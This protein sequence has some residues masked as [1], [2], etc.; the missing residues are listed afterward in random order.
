MSPEAAEVCAATRT[1]ADLPAL[2]ALVGRFVQRYFPGYGL[3]TGKLNAVEA[4]RFVLSVV[5]EDG[6]EEELFLDQAQAAIKP[7]QWEPLH[8]MDRADEA[9]RAAAGEGS[10]KYNF[11]WPPPSLSRNLV[12]EVPRQRRM[13]EEAERAALWAETLRFEREARRAEAKA[14]KAARAARKAQAQDGP[15]GKKAKAKENGGAKAKG[16]AKAKASM[17]AASA[18]AAAAAGHAN[19]KRGSGANAGERRSLDNSLD[20]AVVIGS[21]QPRAGSKAH[22]DDAKKAA[23]KKA[24][25]L[26]ETADDA[27]RD[28]TTYKAPTHGKPYTLAV[29][30]RL[31]A[32][33]PLAQKEGRGAQHPFLERLACAR[34]TLSSS[35]FLLF[36]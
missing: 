29:S 35:P 28:W 19:E 5:Y 34:S 20:D 27:R 32:V 2:R 22:K 1:A 15:A 16:K 9:Q 24:T 10:K 33:G 26:G 36:L 13:T 11:T 4:Q 21:E 8:L 12:V 7:P 6:D 25:A 14:K 17:A 3:Y 23:K 31:G 18:A 30:Q